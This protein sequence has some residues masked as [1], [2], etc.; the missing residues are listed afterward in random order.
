M[1]ENAAGDVPGDSDELKVTVRVEDGVDAA[2]R[3]QSEPSWRGP[4]E[5]ARERLR[6]LGRKR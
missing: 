1:S 6:N 4:L 2:R 3:R 5:R